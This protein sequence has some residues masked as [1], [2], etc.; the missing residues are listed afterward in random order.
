[1]TTRS[2]CYVSLFLALS[3]LLLVACNQP[4]TSPPE[5]LPAEVQPLASATPLPASAQSEINDFVNQQQT[6]DEQ[7]DQIRVEFDQW[8]AE[9][10]SCHPNSV[11]EALNDFAVTFNDVTEQ[12]RNLTRA[13]STREL[14]DTLIVAA[15]AEETAL[16]QLRDRWQPNN[17][18]LF[19]EVE[20]RRSDASHAQKDAQD[21]AIEL[22]AALEDGIVPESTDEFAQS[23][24]LVNNDWQT[25][26]D[27]YKNLRDTA[28]G[29]EPA[30]VIAGL[31]QLVEKFTLVVD[32]LDELPVQTGAES[33]V[34]ALQSAAQA[35]LEA[36]NTAREP[37]NDPELPN[38]PEL[39]DDP[40]LPDF[41]GIDA[42]VK[43]SD[44][45]LADTIQTIANTPEAD[46]TVPTDPEQGLA[47]LQVFDDEYDRVV[48]TWD[49]FHDRYNDWRA[50]EG[51]CDR[52]E[53]IQA[54]EQFSL[55][56]GA[57]ARDVR[58]LPQAG[59]LLPMYTSLVDAAG[60]EENAIRTLRN[61]WQPFTVD[62]FKAV[63]EDRVNVDGLRREADIA[64]QQLRNRF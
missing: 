60:R 8:R 31:D 53:V 28:E 39:T 43:T 9:L 26:H 4:D 49:E 42:S 62:A 3:L 51:G 57:I 18:A 47:E 48:V 1:M 27:E 29:L 50:S 41:S 64:L 2:F 35:E 7:W 52:T 11:H 44:D 25:V 54:L 17:V 16:R 33:T 5:I 13:Q 24:E 20:R 38:D 59:Y 23:F 61:S 22:R 36:F 10:T 45:A 12:A 19:E 32:A 21:R 14:A 56:T 37:S 55:R 40:E 63:D 6:I 46:P 30:D 34:E 15:E 58:D